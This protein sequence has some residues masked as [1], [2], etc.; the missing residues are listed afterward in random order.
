MEKGQW[1]WG[2]GKGPMTVHSVKRNV[3]EH[4][5]LLKRESDERGG[6]KRP[7]EGG[8]GANKRGAGIKWMCF[9]RKWATWML[10]PTPAQQL[11]FLHSGRRQEVSHLGTEG[12]RQVM[13][14]MGL[15]VAKIQEG[16]WNTTN[17]PIP[18]VLLRSS[19]L[20][21]VGAEVEQSCIGLDL[22]SRYVSSFVYSSVW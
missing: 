12:G 9:W 11:L 6:V 13:G 16:P 19:Y 7:L 15:S 20:K 1:K 18:W 8:Q 4:T 3:K 21:C 5:A 22:G 17:E 10:F 14:S 2:R